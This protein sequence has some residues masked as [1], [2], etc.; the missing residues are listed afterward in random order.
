MKKQ[1]TIKCYR[2]VK[3]NMGLVCG[4]VC[5]LVLGL[6]CGLVCELVCGLVLGLIWG[7]VLGLVF[8]LVL[9]LVVILCNFSEALP[10]ITGFYPILFLIIGIIIMSE[11]LFWVDNAKPKKKQ[12]IFWFTCKRKLENIFEVLLGLSGIAQIYILCREIDIQNYLPTILKWVGYIGIGLIII[13]IVIGM[14][15]LWIKLNSL[16][17]KK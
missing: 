8:G 7:L 17:Y 1:K 10:F 5:G 15:Y 16:K 4:L 14:F 2:F 3:S 11:I 6:V 12:D 13:V 9:G